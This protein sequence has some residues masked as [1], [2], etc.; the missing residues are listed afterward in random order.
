M[1]LAKGADAAT[2]LGSGFSSSVSSALGVSVAA[3]PPVV[4]VYDCFRVPNGLA[5]NDRCGVCNG[6]TSWLSPT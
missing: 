4:I 5:T 6:I 1:Q 2:A 3:T